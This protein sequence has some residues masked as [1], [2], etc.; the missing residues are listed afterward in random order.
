[1]LYLNWFPAS[2]MQSSL[3]QTTTQEPL[4]AF[5]MTMLL[6][7]DGPLKLSHSS[8]VIFKFIGV[9]SLT[10]CSKISSSIWLKNNSKPRW[11][12]AGFQIDLGHNAGLSEKSSES[13]YQKF[14]LIR[15]LLANCS[16]SLWS[17]GSLRDLWTGKNS[18]PFSKTWIS[19]SI[20]WML[21][22]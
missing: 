22:E 9:E 13:S 12:W 3:H 8:L 5:L 11:L 7:S 15:I 16:K 21:F 20:I 1:M 10:R 6:S 19:I 14:H 18:K 17:S 4:S 2:L